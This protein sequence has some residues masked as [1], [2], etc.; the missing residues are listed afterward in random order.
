MR[1]LLTCLIF[2]MTSCRRP[3][4][5]PPRAPDP[6][7]EVVVIPAPEVVCDLGNTPAPAT[8]ERAPGSVVLHGDHY[9]VQVDR[10]RDLVA[11]EASFPSYIGALHA[12]LLR[13]GVRIVDSK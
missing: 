1:I 10:F 12:C 3:S 2:S 13:A 6:P 7:P 8:L 9:D 4:P 11:R 5:A